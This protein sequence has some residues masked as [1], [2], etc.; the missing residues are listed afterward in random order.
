MSSPAPSAARE[1]A[2]PSSVSSWKSVAAVSG[3]TVVLGAVDARRGPK[4][5]TPAIEP[6]TSCTSTSAA[7]SALAPAR[8]PRR[9]RRRRPRARRARARA[10]RR[11]RARARRTRP[12]SRP[13]SARRRRAIPP[14]PPRGGE[15]RSPPR[16]H[17]SSTAIEPRS[18]ASARSAS[19]TRNGVRAAADAAAGRAR[20]GARARAAPRRSISTRARGGRIRCARARREALGAL[21]LEPRH[22][23]VVVRGRRHAA[24]DRRVARAVLLGDLHAR[25][26]RATR[27]S[28][29]ATSSPRVGLVARGGRGRGLGARA[30]RGRRP[31]RA[32]VVVASNSR[33]RARVSRCADRRPRAPARAR[34][35]RGRA[36]AAATFAGTAASAFA[37]QLGPSATKPS[38]ATSRAR[39]ACGRS[40]R[41]IVPPGGSS[42]TLSRSTLPRARSSAH[43]ALAGSRSGRSCRFTTMRRS[44]RS[45]I[46]GRSRQLVGD[47]GR[48]R[49]V[50]F[51]RLRLHHVAR[52]GRAAMATVV[53]TR[54]SRVGDSG[55]HGPRRGC[56]RS[57]SNLLADPDEPDSVFPGVNLIDDGGDERGARK[58]RGPLG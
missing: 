1:T 50:A 43:R 41:Q 42:A 40:R 3:T 51:E 54:R 23:P 14:P 35:A 18:S 11:P 52:R 5:S 32:G 33:R 19:T 9:P 6:K 45:G 8:P 15:R 53:G 7:R 30:L 58:R 10:A 55:H 22:G 38:A 27:A 21:L 12:R 36:R 13:P 49:V 56:D 31:R 2:A 34:R 25:V 37:F 44:A 57:R 39:G 24:N 48:P 46:G 47:D 4:P 28:S 26:A 17:D 29:A 16:A 20:G